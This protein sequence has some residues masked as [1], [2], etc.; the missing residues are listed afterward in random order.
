[1]KKTITLA[2]LALLT[3]LLTTAFIT[4]INNNGVAGYAGSPGESNCGAC[5]GGGSSI[6]SG[7]TVSATP[8]FSNNEYIPGTVYNVSVS[9]QATGFTRFGL[10]CEILNTSSA[11]AGTM[12]AAGAGVKF[13]N[14]GNGQRNAVHSAV[15][16]VS[17]GAGVFSFQWV[18]PAQGEGD[19]TFYYCGN[20][21]NGNNNTSGDLP[22]AGNMMLTEG[23]VTITTSIGNSEMP[24]SKISV[25]PNPATDYLTVSYFAS[26]NTNLSA[27]LFDI[28]GKKIKSLMNE[29]QTPGIHEKTISLQG[30]EPGIYFVKL[31]S[32][33]KK[34]SQ[35]M[36]V[37]N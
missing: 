23:V 22:I 26:K 14:A 13:L 31:N 18:A 33:G 2:T 4:K 27:E 25:F 35:K 30:I 34:V 29:N 10:G 37:K 5:H 7:V 17:S 12:Q 19:V 15:K 1:M 21:V 20:A 16:T 3:F 9:V 32:D 36:I 28:N 8:S 24:V 6:T 11:N